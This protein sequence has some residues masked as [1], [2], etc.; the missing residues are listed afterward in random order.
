MINSDNEGGIFGIVFGIVM[1]V[2]FSVTI[3]VLADK[4]LG[5]SSQQN[6]LQREITLDANHLLDLQREYQRL[7][8]NE[9][10]RVRY[11]VTLDK[12]H[13][14]FK[15]TTQRGQQALSEKRQRITALHA[16]IHALE[17]S[18]AQFRQRQRES[19]WTNAIG[20]NIGILTTVEGKTYEEVVIRKVTE[21]GM[22]ISH[23]NGLS[24]IEANNLPQSW[25]Q[26]FHWNVK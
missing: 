10:A 19:T 14:Y 25:S 11:S 18:F 9:S 15:T 8:D 7:T 3:G 26:R 23:K 4:R 24:R 6:E 21:H 12:Q 5:F 16:E 1:L 2:L 22:E 17:N 13:S 20:E